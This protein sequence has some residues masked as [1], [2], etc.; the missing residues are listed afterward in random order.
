MAIR[1]IRGPSLGVVGML[2]V[3][4]G[5]GA[6]A[7][8]P[9]QRENANPR[10]RQIIATVV[11]KDNK[12]V[13]GLPAA[14]F[15]IRED[16]IDREVLRVEAATDP[17]SVIL[18]ADTTTAFR[19]FERDLRTAPQ[20]F[21]RTFMAAH[22]GSFAALWEFGGA[23]IPVQGFTSNAVLLEQATTKLFPKGSLTGIDFNDL[24]DASNPASFGQNVVASNLLEA[25]R[26]AARDLGKQQHTRRIIVS[27]NS[28]LSVEAS[29]LPGEKV[30]DEVQKANASWFA[31]SLHTG[32]TNG[33]LRDN[34]M[35]GLIPYSGGMRVT[36]SDVAALQPAMKNMADILASQ[37]VVTY[38][39]PS[40]PSPK[41]VAIGI[42]G[43]GLKVM[44]HHWAPK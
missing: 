4:L 5:A 33:P 22:P 35:E 7:N 2:L 21:F 38:G 19:L 17:M 8:A 6:A 11:D 24:G 3:A 29:T 26:D 36:I 20:A 27:F 30:Q 28:D 25:V 14:A 23:G 42:R 39:R 40:G 18:L 44:A 41:I 1:G 32:I 13:T 9:Q 37:Y 15:A 43:A 10:E 16:N 34:V 12:P 31:V